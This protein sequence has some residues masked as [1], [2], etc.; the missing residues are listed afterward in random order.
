MGRIGSAQFSGINSTAGEQ[1][2]DVDL[3]CNTDT[4]IKLVLG[5]LGTGSA[6][7]ILEI[8]RDNDSAKGIALQVLYKGKP[9]IFNSP[10]IPET[11]A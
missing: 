10:M 2:F 7:N 11:E 3:A 1:H 5:S 8:T 4:P 9:I 6:E